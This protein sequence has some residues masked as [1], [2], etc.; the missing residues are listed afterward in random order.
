MG[1]KN[2]FLFHKEIYTFPISV[3]FFY[4]VRKMNVCGCFSVEVIIICNHQQQ[5]QR[6]QRQRRT[7]CSEAFFSIREESL[8]EMMIS[9]MKE[10]W[11]KGGE[12]AKEVKPPFQILLLFLALF[13]VY[14]KNGNIK[15]Y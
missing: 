11:K 5:Q 6:R 3:C 14:L 12:N 10:N 7:P 15:N 9:T 13:S 4:V 8:G 2:G 1:S